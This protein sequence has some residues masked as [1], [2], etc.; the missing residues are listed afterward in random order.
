MPKLSDFPEKSI[1]IFFYN[2]KDECYGYLLFPRNAEFNDLLKKHPGVYFRG[3]FKFSC[4]RFHKV[5][6]MEGNMYVEDDN[7]MKMLIPKHIC[8]VREIK[9][10]T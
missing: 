3:E 10:G 9:N 4:E 7:G 6:R 2:T 1:D 8:L 5:S